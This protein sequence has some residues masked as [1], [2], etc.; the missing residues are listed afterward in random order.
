MK[1][2]IAFLLC[3]SSFYVRAQQT[4][5]NNYKYIVV[6]NQYDFQN[7]AN[8]Y[9]LNELAVFELKKRN[10]I[11]FRNSEVL[12]EDFNRGNCNSLQLKMDESGTL[13]RFLV[14]RL[15]DCTGAIIFETKKGKGTTKSN[16]KAYFEALRDAMTSFDE[17]N[18]TFEKPK[19]IKTLQNSEG[20]AMGIDSV[21]TQTGRP[22]EKA[23]EVKPQE[24][25]KFDEKLNDTKAAE[26][27]KN[28]SE[29]SLPPQPEFVERVSDQIYRT[30]SKEYFIISTETGFDIYKNKG[31]IGTLKKSKGGCYFVETVD[32]M[33][34]GYKTSKGI[35]IEYTYFGKDQ[36]LEFVK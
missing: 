18:Y 25:P 26:T 2:T 34:V 22:G 19:Y 17:V 1:Y 6:A 10:F 36:M 3:I 14:L 16:D 15:V 33:G 35:S 21:L 9:R 7:E 27:D 28:D 20:K 24:L 11:A 13:S 31:L 5:L 8:E 29:V 12:P 23:E 4:D 30:K 32:F